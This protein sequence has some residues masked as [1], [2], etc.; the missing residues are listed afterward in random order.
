MN[1][2][3]LAIVIVIVIAISYMKGDAA[4][5]KKKRN[6]CDLCMI[7]AMG[8][9]AGIGIIG[10]IITSNYEKNIVEKEDVKSI[11]E[12]RWDFLRYEKNESGYDITYTDPRN[13]RSYEVKRQTGDNDASYSLKRTTRH[14]WKCFYIQDVEYE[15]ILSETDYGKV[16]DWVDKQEFENNKR[17]E[18]TYC[19]LEDSYTGSADKE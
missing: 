15:L 10:I 13:S 5:S 11:E 3:I 9:M 18:E 8:L 12:M 2:A 19:V 16:I 4:E 7:V 1:I 14:Y 6:I 17:H